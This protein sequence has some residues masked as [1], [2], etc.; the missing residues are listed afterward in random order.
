MIGSAGRGTLA[1]MHYLVD[2]YNVAHAL[3]GREARRASPE[4]LREALLRRLRRYGHRRRKVT[5]VFD[6]GIA[7]ASPGDRIRGGAELEVR[8]AP[9]ADDEIVSLVR[10]APAPARV[11]VVTRDREVETRSR[12]LGARVVRVIDFL[13][14]LEAHAGPDM[15]PGEPREKY[16][17]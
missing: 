8:Y 1:A 9:S 13:E 5:V 15:E 7:G 2:G 3:F 10:D 17:P 16:D 6:G 14:E 4:E 11:R 12:S